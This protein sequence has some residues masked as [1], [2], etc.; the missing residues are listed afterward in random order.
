MRTLPP[1]LQF[2]SSLEMSMPSELASQCQDSPAVHI[3]SQDST[4]ASQDMPS[5]DVLHP[6]PPEDLFADS[7]DLDL[8]VGSYY[9]TSDPDLKHSIEDF[10]GD[11]QSNTQGSTE[12]PLDFY[13]VNNSAA[14]S[15]EAPVLSPLPSTLSVGVKQDSFA[16]GPTAPTAN[17]VSV[18]ALTAKP[19]SST[20]T[21]RTR[22]SRRRLVAGRDS[23]NTRDRRSAPSKSPMKKENASRKSSSS[24]SSRKSKAPRDTLASRT[25]AAKKRKKMPVEEQKRRNCESAKR[26]RIKKQIALQQATLRAEKAEEANR[27]LLERFDALRNWGYKMGVHLAAHKD[28]KDCSLLRQQQQLEQLLSSP[29]NSPHIR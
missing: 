17:P 20:A 18:M 2:A 27:L 26:S 3:Y 14:S 12:L 6:S 8:D 25:A 4:K 22:Q 19:T 21:S 9:D 5:V 16:L 13:R 24:S 15:L 29:V 23:T 28:C 1:Q 11:S 7:L 10:Y